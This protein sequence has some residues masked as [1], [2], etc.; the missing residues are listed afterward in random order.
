M[1]TAGNAATMG[2]VRSIAHRPEQA[3]QHV[4]DRELLIGTVLLIAI[5]LLSAGLVP[6]LG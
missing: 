4:S 6:I 1:V 5:I 2:I 3:A